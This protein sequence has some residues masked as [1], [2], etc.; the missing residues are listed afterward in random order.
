MLLDLGGIPREIRGSAAAQP[1]LARGEDAAGIAEA[2]RNAQRRL[3]RDA[4]HT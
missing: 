3:W 4:V 2:G 1:Q